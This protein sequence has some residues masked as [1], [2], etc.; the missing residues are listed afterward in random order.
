MRYT[1]L[2]ILTGVFD[3]ERFPFAGQRL[4]ELFIFRVL[5][6]VFFVENVDGS[7]QVMLSVHGDCAAINV[8]VACDHVAHREVP[9][10]PMRIFIIFQKDSEER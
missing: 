5:K 8:T 2:N 10:A 7:E 1:I 3:V 9:R 6:R 4:D